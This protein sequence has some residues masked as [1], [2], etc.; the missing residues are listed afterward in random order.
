MK[1]RFFT[2]I[3]FL[4]CYT[5]SIAQLSISPIQTASQLAST[6]V[7][8]SGTLGVSISNTSLQCNGNANGLFSGTSNFGLT[9]GIVLGTGDVQTSGIAPNLYFGL[10]GKAINDASTVLNFAGD[11]SLNNIISTSTYD[12]CVLEFDLQP[13][14]NFVEFEYV[15]GSEEYPE[16]NCSA[17]NDV[18]GFFISGVGYPV[19]TNIALI[20]TTSLPVSINSI[21]D[22]TGGTCSNYT[23][24]YVANNDTTNTMDGFTVPLIAH[25]P[26]TSGQTYHL[27][28]AIADAGDMI[29]NSYVLLKANSLKSG[30][31]SANNLTS[32]EKKYQLNIYPSILEHNVFVENKSNS[33]WQLKI[34]DLSGVLVQNFLVNKYSNRMTIAVDNLSTGIYIL[35]CTNQDNGVVLT[36][37]VVKN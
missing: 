19:P 10:D 2:T 22:G 6:L 7:A 3:Y 29:L 32:W 26:V 24:L 21:N 9:N 31:T 37:K 35:T 17:F 36:T 4:L 1:L 18:F 28:L 16:F 8:T 34:Y 15:F 27:K 14:G 13:V 33:D 20:P 25:V 30:N 11:S 23:S 5:I 12:A